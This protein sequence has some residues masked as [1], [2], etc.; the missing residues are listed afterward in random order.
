M[1]FFMVIVF[2]KII[3]YS[4]FL[5]VFSI[6]KNRRKDYRRFSRCVSIEF[7]IDFFS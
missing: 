7:F 2:F 4:I 1:V 3:I 5:T 6:F